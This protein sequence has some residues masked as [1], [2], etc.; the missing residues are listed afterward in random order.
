M[1]NETEA[2]YPRPSITATVMGPTVRSPFQLQIKS[3]GIDA[4]GNGSADTHEMQVNLNCP[5][6]GPEVLS[7]GNFRHGAIQFT[8][9]NKYEIVGGESLFNRTGPFYTD[10]HP[11]VE[12]KPPAGAVLNYVKSTF[13]SRGRTVGDFQIA[14]NSD[15]S[16]HW[17]GSFRIAFKLL[18][19]PVSN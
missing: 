5:V 13:V 7:V 6:S 17:Q 4:N 14:E 18:F 2:T 11:T 8:I 10:K 15:E 16:A 3:W 9:D 12:P 19:K 1:P